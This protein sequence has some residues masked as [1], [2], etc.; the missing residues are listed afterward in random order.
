MIAW[1]PANPDDLGHPERQ[2]CPERN[3]GHHQLVIAGPVHHRV[4]RCAFCGL[5]ESTL[6]AEMKGARS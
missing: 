3:G 6:R 2:P 1:R 4:M 5:A